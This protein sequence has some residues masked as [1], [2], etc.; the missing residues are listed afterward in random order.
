MKRW[1][2][3]STRQL[4]DH[5]RLTVYEDEV[6]L[7]GGQ[8]TGYIHFGL[9][10]G[11][12]CVITIDGQGRILLQRE[13]SYPPDEWLYQIPGGGIEKD[14]TPEVAADREMT[15]EAGLTGSLQELGWF[16]PDNRRRADKMRVFLATNLKPKEGKQDLEE[17]FES[18]WFSTEQ[19]ENMIA[20]GEIHNYATLAAWTFLKAHQKN[21]NFPGRK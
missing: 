2:K 3:I 9:R 6:E 12:V 20:I 10:Y 1:K 5:P 16:Y 21:D 18:F 13:Y 7:P 11:S 17:A 8:R 19:I 15:E 4:L 14:E